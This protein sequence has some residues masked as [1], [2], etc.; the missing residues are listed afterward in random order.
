MLASNFLENL[1]RLSSQDLTQIKGFGPILAQ[2]LVDFTRS[3][4]FHKLLQKFTDLE[5]NQIFLNIKINQNTVIDGPLLGQTIC[6]TGSFDQSREDLK[7]Y[8]KSLGA[9]TTDS[10]TKKTS[11]LV[12][13]ADPGSKVAK[14]IEL[15]ILVFESVTELQNRFS[16]I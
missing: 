2:N 13:G 6:I 1:Q 11:I 5:Q 15:G 3:D 16:I 4:R 12:V 9:A 14:A 8:F 10:V 7:K